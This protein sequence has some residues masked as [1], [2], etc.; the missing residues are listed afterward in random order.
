MS[1][2]LHLKTHRPAF[3]GIFDQDYLQQPAFD[4]AN[5][6]SIGANQN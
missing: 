1:S 3:D 5:L 4:L 2:N 6:H